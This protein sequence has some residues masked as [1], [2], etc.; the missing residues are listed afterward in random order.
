VAALVSARRA[1]ILRAFIVVAVVVAAV[2]A[3]AATKPGTFRVERSRSIKAPPEKIFA[4]INDF[5]SWSRWAPQDQEDPSMKRTYRGAESGTG[6]LSEWNSSGSAGR[7]QMSI[8]ESV[9]PRQISVKVDFVKPFEAHN[10]NVFKLEPEGDSTK[11]IWIM[12]G[13][14]LYIMKIMSVFVNMDRMM[15]KHF[16]A[17]LDNLKALAEE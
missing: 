7:G 3:F 13:T 9:A 8:T 15:G 4:L 10:M 12:Q 17:G 14:N 2:L 6:A 5:H 1:M 16:E 11:V